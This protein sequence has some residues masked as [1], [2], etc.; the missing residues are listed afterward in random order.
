[1]PEMYENTLFLKLADRNTFVIKTIEN[2]QKEQIAHGGSRRH[3]CKENYCLLPD[4]WPLL[5]VQIARPMTVRWS[6]I[7]IYGG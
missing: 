7:Q 1:M 3:V 4:R 6:R 2:L 5:S